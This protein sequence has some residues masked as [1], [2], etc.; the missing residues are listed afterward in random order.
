MTRQ[1]DARKSRRQA[2]RQARTLARP[3]VTRFLAERCV[4][5]RNELEPS[6]APIIYAAYLVWCQDRSSAPITPGDLHAIAGARWVVEPAHYP[7]ALALAARH[8]YRERDLAERYKLQ[9][10]STYGKIKQ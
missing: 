6:E 8:G 10:S 9:T 2:S 5:P 1:S 7:K 3:I 4:P